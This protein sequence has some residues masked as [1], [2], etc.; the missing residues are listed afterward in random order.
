ML[1][2][3]APS[4]PPKGLAGSSETN[5]SVRLTWQPPD[6]DSLN[7]VLQGYTIQYKLAGYSTFQNKTVTLLGISLQYIL[8]SLAYFQEYQIR[9]AAYNI[10]GVGVFS[11]L[12]NVSCL[13]C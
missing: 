2:F 8:Q 5:T 10:K 9:I 4:S 13:S 7:G 12:I 3:A 11:D 6:E 1:V